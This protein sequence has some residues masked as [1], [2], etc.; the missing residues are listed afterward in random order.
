MHLHKTNFINITA[1]EVPKVGFADSSVN[2]F[3][4]FAF[5]DRH[6]FVGF[7]ASYT[8]SFVQSSCKVKYAAKVIQVKAIPLYLQRPK[9]L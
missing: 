5:R 6:F 4:N 2:S 8:I 3:A 7:L 1:G 9:Y